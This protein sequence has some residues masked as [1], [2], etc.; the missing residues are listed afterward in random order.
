MATAVRDAVSRLN[1]T[2]AAAAKASLAV[3]L[4]TTAHQ[5]TGGVEQ[6]VVEAK[7]YKQL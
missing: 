2:L 3:T 5:T 7:I 1:A 6:V 4:T